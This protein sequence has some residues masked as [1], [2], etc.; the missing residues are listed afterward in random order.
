M[1]TDQFVDHLLKASEQQLTVSSFPI[2]NIN[3]YAAIMETQTTLPG[4]RINW[5]TSGPTGLS[6]SISLS[7]LAHTGGHIHEG[8]PTGEVS[9]SSFV[10]GQYPQNVRSEFH[11]P[12]AGGS[13]QQTTTVSNGKSITNINR[14]L[15][16][17][18][19]ELVSG[20]G[21]ILSGSTPTHPGNHYGK[22]LLLQKLS[23]LAVAFH[24]N[25]NKK[26]FI[27]DMS[28][29]GGGLFDIKATWSPPHKTHRNGLIADVNST[30][31]TEDEKRWFGTKCV[32]LGIT[33]VLETN[34]PHWHLS[35]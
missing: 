35:L 31:M 4:G 6:V 15:I 26:I 20:S 29:E 19:I 7:R 1:N 14:I 16:P 27:N 18:L 11:A 17:D 8:G 9:P 13:I 32:A 28:L 3:Q 25:F 34:P 30:T 12:E 2:D 24:H 22:P 33:A 5:Y 21:F 23:E 10:L